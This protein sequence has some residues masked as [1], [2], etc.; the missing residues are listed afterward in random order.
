MSRRGIDTRSTFHPPPGGSAYASPARSTTTIVAR[1]AGLVQ[2]S[3]RRHVGD[4]VG[5]QDEEELAVG[6]RQRFEGVGGH[7][8]RVALDLDRR[9]DSTPS[10]PSTAASTSTRRSRGRGHDPAALLPRVAGH[11]E[12]HAIEAEGAAGLDRDDDVRDVHGIERA[13]EHPQALHTGSLRVHPCLHSAETLASSSPVPSWGELSPRP[14]PGLAPRPARRAR[15]RRVA[16]RFGRR[17]HR[18]HRRA[19]AGRRRGGRRVRGGAA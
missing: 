13:A 4:R 12:Q 11:H 17:R 8:R 1:C 3:P 2:P 7:R 6:R 9:R 15:A 14:D 5:T 18:R 19:R 10:T 16:H